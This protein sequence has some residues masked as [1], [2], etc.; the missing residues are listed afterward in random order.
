MGVVVSR[1]L[2]RVLAGGQPSEKTAIEKAGTRIGYGVSDVI[3][4]HVQVAT[5]GSS[6]GAKIEITTKAAPAK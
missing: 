5:R 2:L 3:E 4:D 6:A 1:D